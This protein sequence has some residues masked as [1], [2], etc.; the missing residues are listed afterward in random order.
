MM[1]LMMESI[2]LKKL[3]KKKRLFDMFCPSKEQDEVDEEEDKG[4]LSRK[5]VNQIF[6][7]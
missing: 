4:I 7:A 3:K 1:E 5:E 6:F 2:N